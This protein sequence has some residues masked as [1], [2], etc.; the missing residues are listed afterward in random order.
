M[1]ALIGEMLAA[2]LYA[3]FGLA[4]RRAARRAA[5]LEGTLT[6]VLEAEAAAGCETEPYVEWIAVPAPWRN[7]KLLRPWHARAL[8]IPL[9][10]RFRRRGAFG[11]GPPARAL[12]SGRQQT[13]TE[14]APC[15][16]HFARP[17]AG[18][19]ASAEGR[20]FDLGR[21]PAVRPRPKMGS[22]GRPAERVARDVEPVTVSN[23]PQ[24]FG[25]AMRPRFEQLRVAANPFNTLD[26]SGCP[27]RCGSFRRSSS[28][29]LTWE[30]GGA[31]K[32]GGLNA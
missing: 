28:R 8:S 31:W 10:C 12:T 2:L 25:N 11:R 19:S 4:L 27:T 29:R 7:G 16:G 20:L 22:A 23:P 26:R 14:Q 17:L 3:L 6:P 15:A 24:C 30:R 5:A 32:Q 13:G 21:R 1:A 9:P 18:C